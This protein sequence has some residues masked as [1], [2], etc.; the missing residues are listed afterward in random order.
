MAA[1]RRGNFPP[2]QQRQP[3][4]QQQ[5]GQNVMGQDGKLK[6]AA[7]PA[8]AVQ[9][10]D[11]RRTKS[12]KFTMAQLRQTDGLVPL[13]DVTGFGMPR[14]TKTKVEFADDNK[15]YR[16]EELTTRDNLIRLQS[17]TNRFESQKK[18]TSFGTPRDVKGKHLKRIWEL[19]FPDEVDQQQPINY[20]QNNGDYYAPPPQPQS[21]AHSPRQPQQPQA[22]RF[23][24]SPAQRPQQG[25]PQF[26]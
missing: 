17:G 24:Q 10:G 3:P 7:A 11:Q 8:N 25:A 13:Q 19:E 18:M 6:I 16:V 1:I 20:Q 5:D 4:P 9:A 14:N 23:Q 26:R 22:Q 2:Q 12:G 21:A 15:R